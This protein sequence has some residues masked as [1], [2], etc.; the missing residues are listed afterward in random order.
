MANPNH[1]RSAGK[2]RHLRLIIATAVLL[3]GGSLTPHAIALGDAVMEWNQIA[4]AATVS[5][6]QGPLPQSRS[7]TI[8]QVAVHDAVNGITNK[9][10]TYL[11][12]GPAPAGAS[13][14]AAAIAAAHRALSTLFPSQSSTLTP[15]RAASLAARNLTETNPGIGWGE[16]VANSIL[17]AR[18]NDG[19]SQ[20]QFTYAAA[21]AGSPGV[22]VP[23]GTAAAVL[24]GWGN[25]TPWVLHNDSQFH[26]E[27]P[28]P[29]QSARYA[30]DYREV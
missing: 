30:R 15:A 9:H 7:M 3:L 29:L 10:D 16:Q 5:A 12:Y 6:G 23:V 20:A 25:L 17:A 27:G 14:E 26:P 19:A 11:P 8:V 4:L 22:W 1:I 28:P 2:G 24:P 13:P 18:L 21:G